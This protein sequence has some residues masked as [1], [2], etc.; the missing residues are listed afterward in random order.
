MQTI[1]LVEDDQK[2]S[3]NL[4]DFL[5][6]EGYDVCSAPGQQKAMELLG[7]NAC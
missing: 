1:L 3:R 2:I 5:R 4:T 6:S 7:K